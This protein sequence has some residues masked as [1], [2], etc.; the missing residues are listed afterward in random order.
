MYAVCA[1]WLQRMLELVEALVLER[2]ARIMAQEVTQGAT[3][4]LRGFAHCG[5]RL[6]SRR[7][8]GCNRCNH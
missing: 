5:R 4:Q 7:C 3:A 2:A 1:C 6:G 8:S